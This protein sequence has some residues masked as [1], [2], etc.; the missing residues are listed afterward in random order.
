MISGTLLYYLS[1]FISLTV[2]FI[3]SVILREC[4][5]CGITVCCLNFANNYKFVLKMIKSR[6]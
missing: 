1:H 5:P 3:E 2:R 6:S 4:V